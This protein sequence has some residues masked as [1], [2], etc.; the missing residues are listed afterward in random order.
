MNISTP[1]NL[2]QAICNGAFY[3]WK[4]LKYMDHING[5][6]DIAVDSSRAHG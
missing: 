5:L 6:Y 3:I 1:L 4:M 2:S